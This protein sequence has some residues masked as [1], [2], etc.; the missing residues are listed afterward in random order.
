MTTAVFH[1][2]ARPRITPPTSPVTVS[3]A[4]PLPPLGEGWDGGVVHAAAAAPTPAL[5]QRG[6]EELRQPYDWRGKAR[7]VWLRVLPPLLG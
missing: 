5:P 7:D 2:P 1:M 4:L 3:R 6:R